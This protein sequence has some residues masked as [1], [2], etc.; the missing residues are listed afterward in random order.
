MNLGI[1]LGRDVSAANYL[2]E[3]LDELCVEEDAAAVLAALKAG[4]ALERCQMGRATRQWRIVVRAAEALGR[5]ARESGLPMQRLA[6]HIDRVRD[7]LDQ[8]LF[9]GRLPADIA[10]LASRTAAKMAALALKRAIL[11]YWD[12]PSPEKPVCNF[13]LHA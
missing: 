5:S 6:T 9:D 8:V 2:R 11:A 4:I 12:H 3:H 13:P 1:E 10:T 7:S